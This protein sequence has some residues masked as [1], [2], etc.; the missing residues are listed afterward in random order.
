MGNSRV[1]PLAGARIE[2]PSMNSTITAVVSLPSRERE[3]KRSS[4]DLGVTPH[5]VAP[6]AGARIETAGRWCRSPLSSVAPLAG[7]RIETAVGRA[8]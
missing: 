6:L 5:N 1:A 8:G 2:T 4:S 7:A 3:L